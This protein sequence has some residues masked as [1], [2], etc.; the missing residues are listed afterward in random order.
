MSLLARPVRAAWRAARTCLRF[1]LKA[2]KVLFILAMVALPAPL[3][4]LLFAI[5]VRGERRNLPAEV[6][7]KD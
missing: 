2:L 7:R 6:L 4:T 1:T 3:T 5:V